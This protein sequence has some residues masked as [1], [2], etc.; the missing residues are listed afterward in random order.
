MHARTLLVAWAVLMA[1]FAQTLVVDGQSQQTQDVTPGIGV[2]YAR[3]ISSAKEASSKGKHELAAELY[4]KALAINEDDGEVYYFLGRAQ[5]AVRRYKDAANSF[6]KA[7]RGGFYEA[8]N[9]A[10]QI[11]ACLAQSG[12]NEA[13]FRWLEEAL[14]CRFRSRLQIAED[15]RFD[16]LR[17]I[18]RF[19]KIIGELP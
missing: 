17:T 1:A 9:G 4:G 8:A 11:A 15:K 3:L 10:Y 18:P 7:R 2:E 14:R 19:K 16:S 6:E 5:S 13:A 12:E